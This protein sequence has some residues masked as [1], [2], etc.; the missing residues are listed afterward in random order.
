MRNVGVALRETGGA[1]V[2]A[3]LDA[4]EAAVIVSIE[5]FTFDVEAVANRV[6]DL[7]ATEPKTTHYLIDADGLGGALWEICAPE[8][9]GKTWELYEGRGIQR[10]ELISYLL[11]LIHADAL[12]FA[13]D[14]PAME[15]MT[16]A[17][18]S[19]RRQVGEDGQIGSE[20]VAALCLAITPPPRGRT[21]NA[22]LA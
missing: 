5:P 16:K 14:L 2:I 13:P 18:T 3:E 22:F 15:Q 1:V 17:L 12:H 20:L 8:R 9:P 6:L 10:Q 11:A 7:A 21:W 4:D 19:Y